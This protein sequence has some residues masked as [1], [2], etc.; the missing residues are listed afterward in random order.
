MPLAIIAPVAGLPVGPATEATVRDLLGLAES[1]DLQNPSLELAINAANVFVSRLPIV[2]DDLLADVDLVNP[3][4]EFAWTHDVVQGSTMLAARIF[5]RRNSTEGVAAFG[6]QGAIYV[7][8]NDP[9]VAMLLR[10]GAYAR[11]AVG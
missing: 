1:D 11:P 4:A 5:K 8:R 6:D 9:D 2:V 7:Q 10:I 3:P